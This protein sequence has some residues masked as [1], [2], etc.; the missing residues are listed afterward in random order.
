MNTEKKYFRNLYADGSWLI[1][2]CDSKN[3]FVLIDLILDQDCLG[4]TDNDTVSVL[5]L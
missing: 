4:V 3:S 1:I 5:V 2:F